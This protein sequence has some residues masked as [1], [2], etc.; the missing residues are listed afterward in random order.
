MVDRAG[1]RQDQGH[2]LMTYLGD[3]IA[4]EF[5]EIKKKLKRGYDLKY[6]L[7]NLL[8]KLNAV[9]DR[10]YERRTYPVTTEDF[11]RF[12]QSRKRT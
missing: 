8:I 6:K 4:D 11:K 5:L 1:I 7:V 3:P 2:I 10:Q 12:Y 9:T